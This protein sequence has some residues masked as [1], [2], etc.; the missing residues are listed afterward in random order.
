MEKYNKFHI[1]ELITNS[2]ETKISIEKK[3]YF[4]TIKNYQSKKRCIS[5]F[6]KN[7]KFNK[8]DYRPFVLIVSNILNQKIEI[9]S[10][11]NYFDERTKIEIEQINS[12]INIDNQNQQNRVCLEYNYSIISLDT[13][14]TNFEKRIRAFLYQEIFL[15][16]DFSEVNNYLKMLNKKVIKSNKK[17]STLL[18]S[19][20]AFF[21][22]LLYKYPRL[23]EL[24]KLDFY[25]FYEEKD[26][27]LSFVPNEPMMDWN[28]N[29]NILPKVM[30]LYLPHENNGFLKTNNNTIEFDE[31]LLKDKLLNLPSNIINYQCINKFVYIRHNSILFKVPWVK[32][33]NDDSKSL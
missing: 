19:P 18:L 11:T 29:L 9:D 20:Y 15:E 28:S 25:F 13:V 31:Y 1:L 8:V 3:E 21:N 10:L 12:K 5:K 17:I 4:Y 2:K 16:N 26:S 23:N 32:C 6:A 33:L 22:I 7:H 14:Y 27:L 24:N 30:G